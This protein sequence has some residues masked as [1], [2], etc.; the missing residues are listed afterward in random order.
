M[1]LTL[2]KENTNLKN[3]ISVLVNDNIE[4]K[5]QLKEALDQIKLLLSK[6]WGKSSEKGN[7]ETDISNEAEVFK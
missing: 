1:P 2:I 7:Y 3:Q 6:L 5:A 4:L